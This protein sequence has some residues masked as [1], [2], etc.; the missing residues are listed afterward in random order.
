MMASDQVAV[1]PRGVDGVP[2][3]APVASGAPTA[4]EPVVISRLG[5]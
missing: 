2:E 4:G 1:G 3:P 5:V